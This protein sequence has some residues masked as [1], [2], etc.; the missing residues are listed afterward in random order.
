MPAGAKY[1]SAARKTRQGQSCTEGFM[2]FIMTALLIAAFIM[3]FEILIP[4]NEFYI[5]G[6]GT[7]FVSFEF[8]RMNAYY[9]NTFASMI[10]LLI[11]AM[12]IRFHKRSVNKR[13]MKYASGM[14]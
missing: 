6:V 4:G 8:Y 3:L 10:G 1:T 14:N 5:P 9:F 11:A 12:V 7:Y 13:I 2:Y